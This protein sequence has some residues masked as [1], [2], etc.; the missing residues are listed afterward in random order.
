MRARQRISDDPRL[1]VALILSLVSG[2]SGERA[3]TTAVHGKVTFKGQPLGGGVIA[4]HP[5]KIDAGLPSRTAQGAIDA[6]GHYTLSTF[7]LDDGA[8]PGEYAVTVFNPPAAAP[9]DEYSKAPKSGQG[10]T[11]PAHYADAQ[12]TP[13]KATVSVPPGGAQQIDFELKD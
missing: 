5:V 1:A 13:L 10:V 11:I 3:L 9:I 8:V 12:R 6:E 4:F 2:C 7:K